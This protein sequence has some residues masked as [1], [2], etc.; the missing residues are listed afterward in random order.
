MSR[1]PHRDIPAC[2]ECHGPAAHPKNPLYPTLTGQH[3]R[4]LISQ[5]SL[6]QER[7][8]GGTPNVN[9]MHVFVSRLRADEIAD[10]AEYYSTSR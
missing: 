9:L 10:V 6:L 1:I 3:A 2:V 7:R 5:L 8:R 4:Y